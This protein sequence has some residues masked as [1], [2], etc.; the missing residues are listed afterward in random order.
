MAVPH[1]FVGERCRPDPDDFRRA[2]A[3][4]R[5]FG[6]RRAAALKLTWGGDLLSD[7]DSSGGE[8]FPGYRSFVPTRILIRNFDKFVTQSP[9]I[10]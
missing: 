6:D 4:K 2:E 3:D 7:A 1:R 5:S 9:P 10:R 8:S